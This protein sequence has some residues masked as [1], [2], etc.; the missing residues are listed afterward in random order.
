MEK[1]RF[2][3]LRRRAP[4]RLVVPRS[5]RRLARA[6]HAF[7]AATPALF[8]VLGAGF[9]ESCLENDLGMGAV[10]TV[11]G[12]D[13]LR[14]FE[15]ALRGRG[16][17]FAYAGGETVEESTQGAQ[18]IVVA[19]VAGLKPELVA[20]LRAVS[21]RA[22]VTIGPSIPER[23]G[24]MR[25]LDAPHDVRGLELEPL[26]DV[27]RADALV[28]KR[29]EELSLPTYPVDPPEA[30]VCVHEDASGAPKA[31]FLMNP[32]PREL[33]AKVA[34]PGVGA[35]RDVLLGGSARIPRSSGAFEVTLDERSVRMFAVE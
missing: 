33:V 31:V 28:A 10:A 20:S 21:E 29:I 22:R 26:D 4:V 19:T 18:W 17:P 24:N 1:T 3:T 13:Y 16:V 6:T 32:T 9:R 34:L 15:R 30:F 27:A 23:D 14:A 2:H 8:N 5:L 25:K 12:E 7:G 11:A 35:L